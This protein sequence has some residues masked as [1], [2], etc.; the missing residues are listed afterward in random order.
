M[1][2]IYFLLVDNGD[3]SHDKPDFDLLPVTYTAASRHQDYLL[4]NFSGSDL[5]VEGRSVRKNH[6]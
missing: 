2:F 1:R 3:P 4:R 5:D 6:L